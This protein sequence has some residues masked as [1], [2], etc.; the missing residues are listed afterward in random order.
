VDRSEPFRDQRLLQRQ[1]VQ[2]WDV[3]L[4]IRD[5]CSDDLAELVELFRRAVREVASED[6]KEQA[7]AWAPDQIRLLTIGSP[8][9]RI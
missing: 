3:T 5:Y 8:A 7:L 6:T 2:R 4:A 1:R 9:F